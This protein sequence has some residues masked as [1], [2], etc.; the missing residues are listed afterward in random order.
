MKNFI[1]RSFAALALA[2]SASVLSAQSGTELQRISDLEQ[3][4]QALNEK[5]GQMNIQMETM[6]RDND[7]L[8]AQL[9]ASASGIKTNPPAGAG[10]V[11]TTQLDAQLANLRAEMMRAQTAQ[12]D[13]IVDEVSRQM[14]RLAQQTQQ[15]IQA[16][17]APADNGPK[18][19]DNFP[20]TGIP[21]TVQKGDTIS[22]IAHRFNASV[23]DIVNANRIADPTKLKVGQKIIIPQRA[24]NANASPK[25]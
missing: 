15:A 8:R 2:A 1:L 10:F 18:F 3:D 5:I 6:R 11:T 16:Q 19:S 12:K 21:Y 24:A 20:K 4:V 23:D 17:A 13:E 22:G 9:A 7:A 14:E 25:K